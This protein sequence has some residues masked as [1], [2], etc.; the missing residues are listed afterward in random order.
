L[1]LG[2]GT[3]IWLPYFVREFG[4]K[5][6]GVDYSEIGCRQEKQIL[7]Q[8]EVEG[9]IVCADFFNPP[10]YLLE[11]SDYVYSFGVAEHFT[12]TEDCLSAFASFLKPGGTMITMIPNMTGAVGRLQK[13][14]SRSVYDIHVLL[15]DKALQAAH[16]KAGLEIVSCHYLLST[17][18]GLVNTSGLNQSAPLVKIKN[19]I[20]KTLGRLSVLAWFMENKIGRFPVVRSFSPFVF[21][22]ARKPSVHD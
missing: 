4:F 14:A 17:G 8:A 21:C 15:T 10:A 1:A 20:V 11:K 3:S 5:V 6:S 2:C 7:Q 22:V 13:F 18:F 12:P 19:Q 16:Q 9:E